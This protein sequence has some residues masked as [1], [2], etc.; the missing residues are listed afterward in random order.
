MVF[1]VFNTHPYHVCIITIIIII[2][3]TVVSQDDQLP[4]QPNDKLQRR[5]CRPPQQAPP[6]Q[7]LCRP[8]P[9]HKPQGVWVLC[10]EAA[11]W[12]LGWQ[13]TRREGSVQVDNSLYSGAHIVHGAVERSRAC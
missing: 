11:H 6:P 8:L 1:I 7:Q 13:P 9:P 3:R 5:L 4:C 10:Q 2:K 12:A